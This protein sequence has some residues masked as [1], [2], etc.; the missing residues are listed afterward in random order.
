MH[1]QAAVTLPLPFVQVFRC[2]SSAHLDKRNSCE[3]LLGDVC[4]PGKS[5]RL[6]FRK[7]P[8]PVA[9]R[10][11]LLPARGLKLGSCPARGHLPSWTLPMLRG[12]LPGRS[13]PL[14]HAEWV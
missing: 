2:C 3:I 1:A 9:S 5:L 11:V 6:D 10:L 12:M 14:G 7:L 4:P 13:Q 8:A